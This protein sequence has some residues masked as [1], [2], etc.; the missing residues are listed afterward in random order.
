MLT[1]TT[2]ELRQAHVIA[3]LR[4]LPDVRSRPWLA[5]L[6]V[7]ESLP[8]RLLLLHPVWLEG[9]TDA[10]KVQGPAGFGPIKN[11]SRCKADLLWGYACPLAHEPLQS[12]HVFPYSLGGPTTGMN[13]LALCAVHNGW[14][15]AD[16]VNFPWE[17]GEPDWL[18]DQLQTI[19]RVFRARR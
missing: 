7:A 19:R 16:L 2:L 8:E 17:R 12:D 18:G 9:V 1:T 13:R 3:Y 10:W 5:A 15:G 6:E 4:L 11:P 14:K